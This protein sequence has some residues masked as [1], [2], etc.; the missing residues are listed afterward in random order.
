M[1]IVQLLKYN[2]FF[3]MS[4]CCFAI[5]PAAAALQV[6]AHA[7]CTLQV[8]VAGNGWVQVLGVAVVPYFSSVALTP[9]DS[10]A[11]EMGL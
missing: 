5:S 8:T 11:V 2:P 9:V 10:T 4:C 6:S 3:L 7:E 1:H